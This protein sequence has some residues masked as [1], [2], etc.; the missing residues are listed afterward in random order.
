MGTTYDSS[1]AVNANV[2]GIGAVQPLGL[3]ELPETILF[4]DACVMGLSM[5]LFVVGVASGVGLLG[6][7]ELLPRLCP[8]ADL[9]LELAPRRL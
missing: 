3:P 5:R 1:S 2:A 9:E 8:G 6:G 4:H 7:E